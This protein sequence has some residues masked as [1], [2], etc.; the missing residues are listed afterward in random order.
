M[1]TKQ[2]IVELLDHADHR[3]LRLIHRHIVAL[4]GVDLRNI[5]NRKEEENG[6]DYT[7]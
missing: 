5:E 3:Q 6:K 1:D 4:L 7:E 2:R